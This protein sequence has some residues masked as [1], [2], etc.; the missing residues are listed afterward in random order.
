MP[1]AQTV[2]SAVT[3]YT[4]AV[5]AE[6]PA[7]ARAVMLEPLFHSSFPLAGSSAYRTAFGPPSR[8]LESANTTPLTIM[9]A[10]GA[11]SGR[12]THP[13]SSAG[14]PPDCTRLYATTESPVAARIQ[15]VP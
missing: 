4:W 6:R 7:E 12:D 15:R 5:P 14:A 8:P 1:K 13:S 3:A 9:A 2:L 11:T 10:R